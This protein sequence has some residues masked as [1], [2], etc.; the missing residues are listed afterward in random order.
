MTGRRRSLRAVRATAASLACVLSCVSTP[1]MADATAEA[2]ANAAADTATNAAANAATNAATASP[3]SPYSTIVRTQLA[4]HN[5][6]DARASASFFGIDRA[7][8]FLLGA[9]DYNYNIG[10]HSLDMARFQVF[11]GAPLFSGDW[12]RVFGWVVTAD[13]VEIGRINRTQGNVPGNL[14]DVRAGLQV[15][16]QGIP[17][18]RS[19]FRRNQADLFIEVFP[20]RTNDDFGKVEFFVRFSKRFAPKFVSRGVLRAYV[21]N[22][23]TVV[24]VE[25]DFVYEVDKH[26]DVFA[27]LAKANEDWPG[28]AQKRIL[29]G[30]GVRFDF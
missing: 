23:R 4:E 7:G 19:W 5:N 29:I 30:G 24:T 25:N 13:Y 16:A 10:D 1:A 28:L 15:T 6:G 3:S 22:S 21:F 18:L 26:F 14:A 8:D 20:I 12:A 17:L 9:A 11:A 27:R 2:T